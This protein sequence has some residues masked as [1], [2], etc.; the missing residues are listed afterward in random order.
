MAGWTDDAVALGDKSQRYLGP[1]IPL[2]GRAAQPLQA[3]RY[4]ETSGG[5]VVADGEQ[6]SMS[7][8]S[9][10][11]KG[12]MRLVKKRRNLITVGNGSLDLDL[13]R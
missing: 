5:V 13:E 8:L 3:T 4:W 11:R 2:N 9:A 7:L 12:A 6:G 10:T 1:I